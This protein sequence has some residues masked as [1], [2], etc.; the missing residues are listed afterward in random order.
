MTW[1]NHISFR[2]RFHLSKARYLPSLPYRGCGRD[3]MKPDTWK[4]LHKLL[5]KIKG[6]L[7]LGEALE[8]FKVYWICPTCAT[9]DG[10][11][12]DPVVEVYICGL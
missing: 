12:E 5:H 9:G 8:S 6:L 4:V 7:W 1:V 2:L 11:Y 3:Q 10:K